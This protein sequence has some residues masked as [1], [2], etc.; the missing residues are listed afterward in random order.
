MKSSS[1]VPSV[2]GEFGRVEL[3]D[4]RLRHRLQSAVAR[5]SAAPDLGF[6]RAL[7]TERESEGFYRLLNNDRVNYRALVKAHALETRERI[8]E[9]ETFRVIHD[10]TELKFEGEEQREGLGRTRGERRQGFFAHVA[11]AVS[12]GAIARPLGVIGAQCWART[13]PSRGNR[14]LSG[15]QLSKIEDKESARWGK[16]VVEVEDLVGTRGHAVHVMDREGDS[17][18]LFCRL[19]ELSASFVIRVARDR[20]VFEDEDAVDTALLSETLLELPT[21][22]TREVAL[23][24]RT[25]K[26]Q[27]RSNK[28]HPPRVGRMAKLALR[29][30]TVTLQ[31]PVYGGE[32]LPD[33]LTLNVVYVQE[34]ETP[35]DADP[36]SWVLLTTEPVTTA[37]DVE[38][39]VDHYRARWLIEEFFKALKTGCSFEER[40]LESFHSLTNALAIFFP[41]AWQMLL[42]RA[43]SRADPDAPAEQVLTPTQIKVLQH[44]QPQKM[45]LR[46]ATV[47]DALYAV[48]GLGGHLKNNGPPGWRTLSYGMQDL[49]KYAAVWDLAVKSTRKHA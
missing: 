9:G 21:F 25:Q 12:S 44:Y 26:A 45:P 31:R 2:A 36:V 48:A 5:V 24:R 10:T 19:R 1:G 29:A 11:L 17:Y 39:V 22:V 49:V 13:A 33:A 42:L 4:V 6:P 46:G 14:K 7:A 40:Q 23:S 47:H 15:Q 35:S 16:L 34:I 30:G 43:V 20:R 8:A 37:A 32:D 41:I 28:T 18:P 27:P 38:A 3:G